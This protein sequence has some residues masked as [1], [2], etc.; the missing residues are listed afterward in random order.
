MVQTS[1]AERLQRIEKAQ[2]RPVT[3]RMLAGVSE[4]VEKQISSKKSK[5]GGKSA[6]M[7]VGKPI[8]FGAGFLLMFASF[9][10]VRRMSDIHLLLD[11]TD[12]LAPFTS[13][14]MAG[15][16]VAIIFVLIFFAFKLQRATFRVLSEPA[17]IPFAL[18]MLIG[19]AAGLGP[20]ELA[21]T[22]M[23]QLQ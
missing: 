4:E 5:A 18:G 15:I 2:S 6:G 17:R 1:F 3:E 20:A 10:L 13:T 8:R 11:G 12:I 19:L 23:A 16:A 21:D 14:I 9:M 7:G 22:M